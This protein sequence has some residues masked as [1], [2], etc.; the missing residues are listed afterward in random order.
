MENLSK[1]TQGNKKIFLRKEI[2]QERLGEEIYMEDILCQYSVYLVRKFEEQEDYKD[3]AQMEVLLKDLPERFNKDFQDIVT[4]NMYVRTTPKAIYVT[5]L[6]ALPQPLTKFQINELKE[7]MGALTPSIPVL[8][9]TSNFMGTPA[10]PIEMVREWQE[11][12]SEVLLL[13]EMMDQFNASLADVYKELQTVKS[14]KTP[15][16]MKVVKSE[17]AVKKVAEQETENS[18]R[19]DEAIARLD[20][21]SEEFAAF[22][23]QVTQ[24]LEASGTSKKP[25]KFKIYFDGKEKKKGLD[26]RVEQAL[27]QVQAL[28]GKTDSSQREIEKLAMKVE[29]ESR[30]NRELFKGQSP[31]GPIV[32]EEQTT[33][34]EK[35]ATTSQEVSMI[36]HQLKQINDK[37]STVETKVSEVEQ[38]PEERAQKVKEHGQIQET[39]TETMKLNQV[40]DQLTEKLQ[41]VETELTD[42]K[43]QGNKKI[44]TVKLK[45]SDTVKKLSE[46]HN[47]DQEQLKMNATEI[48]KLSQT[49]GKVDVQLIQA[50]QKIAELEQKIRLSGGNPSSNQGQRM[51]D[52]QPSGYQR[53]QQS[54]QPAKE[55]SPMP[56]DHSGTRSFP[57]KETFLQA[58]RPMTAYQQ[59]VNATPAPAPA[60]PVEPQQESP[61]VTLAIEEMLDRVSDY[62]KRAE[63]INGGVMEQPA[64]STTSLRRL[65]KL[66]SEIYASFKRI[67][68]GI[69]SRGM[70]SKE[71]FY[72]GIRQVEVLPYL[73]STIQTGDDPQDILLNNEL[74]CQQL[75]ASVPAFLEEV[76]EIA[77]KRKVMGKWIYCPKEVEQ[78]MEGFKL[79]NEYLELY[80]SNRTPR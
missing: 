8:E 73:W 4:K 11:T 5:L 44:P 25:P 43:K 62:P 74:S 37:L 1:Y 45:K 75:I 68:G 3:L 36:S 50:N 2:E 63:P 39:F 29:K 60:A 57:T 40:I 10:A 7:W 16:V 17:A 67:K 66:E 35:M 27:E 54:A 13:T 79:L 61:T 49:V 72:G 33:L 71:D 24:Q 31:I 47:R 80:L 55:Q 18:R 65:K 23:Q 30:R 20:K 32:V 52:V 19:I 76:E 22:K 58:S 77:S 78:K 56:V 15:P 14:S 38:T 46:Q 48:K 51:G 53:E 41:S 21:M 9:H 69:G 42:V 26:Q 28:V 12:N 59:R 64:L 34:E 70:I 6:L